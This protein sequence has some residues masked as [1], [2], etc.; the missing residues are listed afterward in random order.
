[1]CVCLIL[2]GNLPP[3]SA[4]ISFHYFFYEIEGKWV[5]W[6]DKKERKKFSEWE[7]NVEIAGFEAEKW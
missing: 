7:E 4:I 6:A 5:A 2:S 3:K 1:M